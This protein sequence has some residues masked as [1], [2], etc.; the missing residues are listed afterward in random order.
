MSTALHPSADALAPLPASPGERLDR[1]V[2]AVQALEAERRRLERL[3]LERPLARC[4]EQLRYWRFVRALM[5]VAT[6]EVR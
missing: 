2:R 6:G 3:H 1:S 5:C 4:H